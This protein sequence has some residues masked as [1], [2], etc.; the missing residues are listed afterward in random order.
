MAPPP[1]RGSGLGLLDGQHGD[2]RVAD[3]DRLAELPLDDL[4]E[5]Q[6]SAL[7]HAGARR[8]S[9]DDRG[10][11]RPGPRARPKGSWPSRRRRCGSSCSRRSGRRRRRFPF[12]DRARR[13]SDLLPDL[14]FLEVQAAAASWG[15]RSC[16]APWRRVRGILA[17]R[18]PAISGACGRSRARDQRTGAD[19]SALRGG[20]LVR[21][22]E[23]WQP[24]KSSDSARRLLDEY[25]TKPIHKVYD[26]SPIGRP[27][28]NSIS[29]RSEPPSVWPLRPR[30][31]LTACGA[32]AG[33]AVVSTSA[34][35]VWQRPCRRRL[36]TL[37]G[38]C[39]CRSTRLRPLAPVI[40]P[41]GGTLTAEGPDGTLYTLEIPDGACC[42]ST[43]KS[44]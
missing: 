32:D 20:S 1:S 43:P 3:E 27:Q 39:R 12:G 42:L 15:P 33:P 11:D 29:A 36:P 9:G 22:S 16:S 28:C 8:Q 30:F 5:G 4:A 13:R 21:K 2:H 6:H 41:S 23:S 31:F 7:H 18:A 24:S 19:G 10:H 38:V 17:R 25:R 26:E 40:P 14:E 44:R 37:T 35:T 34:E